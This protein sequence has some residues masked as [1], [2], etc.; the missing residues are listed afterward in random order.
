MKPEQKDNI[1]TSEKL[2]TKSEIA[3]LLKKI[4]SMKF[5][6]SVL[7]NKNHSVQVGKPQTPI[8]I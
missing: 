7:T 6:E 4:E 5:M 2:N 8:N 1:R 3:R